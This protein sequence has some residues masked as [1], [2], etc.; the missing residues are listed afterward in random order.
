MGI[1][2]LDIN[3]SKTSFLSVSLF[4][5]VKKSK[6][7]FP[8]VADPKICFAVFRVTVNIFGG[9]PCDKLISNIMMRHFGIGVLQQFGT[10]W[11]V[12]TLIFVKLLHPISAQGR[13]KL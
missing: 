10:T 9:P 8:S 1:T 11:K 6:N 12:S 4:L 5:A 7:T 2:Y 3:Y 13:T